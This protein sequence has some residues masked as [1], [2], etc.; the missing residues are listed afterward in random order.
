MLGKIAIGAAA[1]MGAAAAYVASRPADYRIA[2]SRTVAA[3]PEVV[4]AHVADFRRWTEWS[5]WERKD[6]ALRREYSGAPSGPGAV[7]SWA[8]NREVGEGRMTI[9]DSRP[10]RS[11]IVRLE[12]VKPLAATSTSQLDLAPA[13][14]GTSITW[15]LSGRRGFIEKAFAAVMDVDAM[16]GAEFDKGLAALDEATSGRRAAPAVGGEPRA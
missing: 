11:V 14:S 7:Y 10:G 6:P 16:V 15:S 9:V 12:F 4:H 3:P 8:G 2:R 5:P 13:G 1:A